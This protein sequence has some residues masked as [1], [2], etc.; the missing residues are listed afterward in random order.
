MKTII[1]AV[2]A[3]VGLLC[4][5]VFWV[6]TL[7][8]EVFLNQVAV[9]IVKQAIVYGL[10]LLVPAMAI[11]GMSGFSM[12]KRRNG[13]LVE[14]KKKRMRFIAANGIFVLIPCAL[15]LNGKAAAGEFDTIFSAVQVLELAVGAAQILLMTQNLRDGI[16]L[17]GK[18]RLASQESKSP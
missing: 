1:H 14:H 3:T 10:F 9:V 18:S 4:I 8:S 16:R 2:S 17:A 12:S 11:T 15:F 6:S 5:A 13:H 7:V